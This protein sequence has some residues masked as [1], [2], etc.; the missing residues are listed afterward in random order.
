MQLSHSNSQASPVLFQIIELEKKYNNSEGVF[1]S[2]SASLKS[3]DEKS[4]I[5]NE[6]PVYSDDVEEGPPKDKYHLVYLIFL[7]QGTGVLFP[8][9]AFISAPDYFGKLYGDGIMLY[10]SVAYSVPNLLGLLIMIKFGS[11]LSMRMK[12]FPAYVLTFF[13]LLAVPILGFAGVDGT[14][15]LVVT[16]I[17]IVLAALCTSLMQGGIFGMAGILP[18]NYTQAVMSGNG[19]A[20]VACSALRI[21]TKLTIEQNRKHVPLLIMTTSAAVYFFVCAIVVLLCI[22]TFWIVMR[23]DFVKYYLDKASHTAG[24]ETQKLTEEYDEISTISNSATTN[25]HPSV[26]TVFKKI[27]LQ[28]VM[29]MSVFWVTL[30]IFPGLAVSVP[31]YYVGTAMAD[32]LPILIGATFNVFDFIGRSAPRWIIMFNAKWVTAPIIARLLFLPL[33][34]FLYKPQIFGLDAFNDSIP[35]LA[36]ALLALSNGYLSSLCM[37]FGPS[38]VDHNEKET[39]GTMMTFFLLLGICLGSNTGLGI[40]QI[41]SAVIPNPVSPYVE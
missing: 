18:A 22:V 41:L 36:M 10:F 5:I 30:S 2:M 26:W 13:I 24:T 27:W 39:A 31:T 15:G 32:W 7:L 16:L 1:F 9:N 11:K 21:I 17:F 19:I 23:T 20:G 40:G 12:M 25:A 4:S 6:V 3:Y 14:P 37:M 33:F 35:L 28:A 29:V 38:N 34:I 8:W